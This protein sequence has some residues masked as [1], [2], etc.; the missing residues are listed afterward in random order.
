[1][2]LTNITIGLLEGLKE[3]EASITHVILETDEDT[4]F[5]DDILSS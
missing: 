4:L 3:I 5:E 2:G 1:M